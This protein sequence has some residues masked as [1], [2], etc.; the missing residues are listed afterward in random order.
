MWVRRREGWDDGCGGSFPYYPRG[1]QYVLLLEGET[2]MQGVRTSTL[3]GGVMMFNGCNS[4]RPGAVLACAV[5][6][7][8]LY[9]YL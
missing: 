4:F 5:L 9:L 3:G 2:D 7:V 1:N 8:Y 6:L